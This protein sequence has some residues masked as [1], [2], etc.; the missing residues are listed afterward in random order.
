MQSLV[1]LGP[2]EPDASTLALSAYWGPWHPDPPYCTWGWLGQAHAA[3][4]FMWE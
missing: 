1:L 3:N 2:G 4:I